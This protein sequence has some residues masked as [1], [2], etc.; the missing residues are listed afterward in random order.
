[1]AFVSGNLALI[2]SVNGF[3]LFRYDTT[4]AMTAVEVPG[5]IDNTDDVQNIGKGDIVLI[6]VWTTA[7][8]SGLPSDFGIQVVV[9]VDDG[10]VNLSPDQLAGTFT[11][12]A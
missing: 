5:Y 2:G 8:R 11:S 7:V 4:D 1:M 12:T 9:D 10:A 6:V 3:N